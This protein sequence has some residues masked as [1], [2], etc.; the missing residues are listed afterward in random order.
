MTLHA[1]LSFREHAAFKRTTDGAMAVN[2]HTGFCYTLNP[3]GAALWDLLKDGRTIGESVQALLA[4]YEADPVVAEA[5]ALRLC[6]ALVSYDL[7]APRAGE[8]P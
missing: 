1:R 6:D 3:T 7:A 8:V 2:L 4:Q 5:D